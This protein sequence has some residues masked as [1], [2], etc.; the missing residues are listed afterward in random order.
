MKMIFC[1]P[2]FGAALLAALLLGGCA[3]APTTS[4]GLAPSLYARLG[5]DAVMTGVVSGTLDRATSSPLTQRSFEGIKIPYLKKSL[6]AHICSISGGGC[7]Y[8]G[9][10]M[11]RTHQ[12]AHIQPSE[13]DAMVGFMREELDRAG[14][15]AGA[16]NDLL[17]LLA[18]MKRDIVPTN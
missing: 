16:K 11:A 1:R 15:D 12:A 2:L 6:T 5:G 10:S 14:V 8:D 4:P 3:T 7:V 13:F 18:P 17:K 9:E